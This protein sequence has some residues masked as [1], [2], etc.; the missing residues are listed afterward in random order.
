[1]TDKPAPEQDPKT[2]RFVT[3]NVGGGRPKGA[4]AK[5][6]EAFLQALQ[7]D[8]EQGGIEAIQVV[9]LEKPDQ[10]LKVIAS[11]LPKE[12]NLNVND[13][14]SMTDDELIERIRELDAAIHPF[15]AG[16][17][18]ATSEGGASEV[19]AEKSSCVH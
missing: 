14:E 1:M 18:G 6:G 17:E 11:L 8:F 10:Y 4:R 16:R 15:L 12:L 19:G 2:G 13:A 9:R 7:E 5:L 3:G